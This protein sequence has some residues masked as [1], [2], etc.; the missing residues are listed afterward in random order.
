MLNYGYES[1]K[2]AAQKGYQNVIASAKLARKNYG[3]YNSNI[4]IGFEVLSYIPVI[5]T[6][7]GLLL[8]IFAT[9]ILAADKYKDSADYEK[10][11]AVILAGSILSLLGFVYIFYNFNSQMKLIRELASITSGIGAGAE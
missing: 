4:T 1:A 11:M 5:L 8:V 2:I 10:F 6:F 9:L 7:I 3:T